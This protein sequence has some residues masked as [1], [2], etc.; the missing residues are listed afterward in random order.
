MAFFSC[1]LHHTQSTKT[2]GLRPMERRDIRQV[3][4][5]LQKYLR[6]FQLAPSM[7]EEEVAHWFFPQDNI[8][9]TYVVEVS[10]ISFYPQDTDGLSVVF[11]IRLNSCCASLSLLRVL[12]GY[13][14]ISLVSTLYPRPWCTTLSIGAWRLLI[15]FT[16]F[17]HKPHYWT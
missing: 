12:V 16:T 10:R 8:I 2:P 15:L 14:Q 4:E 3:T 9:D 5:L 17:I 6:R 13:W 11:S 1:S 7:G